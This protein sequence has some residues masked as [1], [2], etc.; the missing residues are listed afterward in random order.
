MGGG[1]PDTKDGDF[2]TLCVAAL[3]DFGHDEVLMTWSGHLNPLLFGEVA[4]ALGWA[5]TMRVGGDVLMTE[6]AI[7]WQGPGKSTNTYIDKHNLYTNTFRYVQPGVHGQ[8]ATKHIGWESNANTKPLMVNYTQRMVDRDM[9]DIPDKHTVLEMSAYRKTDD[10]GDSSSYGGQ[11]GMHDDAVTS[12]EICCVRLRYNAGS[13]NPEAVINIEDNY[14]G[15]DDDETIP[16]DPFD[17]GDFI[18]SDDEEVEEE[19]LF[20]TGLRA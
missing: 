8:K 18:E 10:F 12:L 16:F 13:G 9:I 20:W 15:S 19:Q 6:L 7:E 11:A 1:D 4:S 14:D 17:D 5:L 2:S 3:N